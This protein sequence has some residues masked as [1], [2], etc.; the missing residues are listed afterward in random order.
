MLLIYEPTPATLRWVNLA[1]AGLALFWF[2]L[3]AIED[4]SRARRERDRMKGGHR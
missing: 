2:V 4:L 3:F 1:L